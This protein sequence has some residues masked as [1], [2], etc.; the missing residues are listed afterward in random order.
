MGAKCY[1]LHA[2]ATRQL[3][4][5]Y[6]GTTLDFIGE[7]FMISIPDKW[8][9]GY[10]GWSCRNHQRDCCAKQ[11][12]RVSSGTDYLQHSNR[13]GI[14]L[15]IFVAVTVFCLGCYLFNLLSEMIFRK[16][17]RKQMRSDF[18]TVCTMI[19]LGGGFLIFHYLLSD[20]P[21]LSI[22][23]LTGYG[24]YLI[25]WLGKKISANNQKKVA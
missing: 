2:H 6:R 9:L 4:I 18:K 19:A 16:P 25:I 23:F 21:F 5:I 1:V 10:A 7:K 12:L 3:R 15:K 22:A 20:I 13:M 11:G 24:L 17:S 8:A 14:N